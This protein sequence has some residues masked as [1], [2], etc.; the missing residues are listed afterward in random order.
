[1]HSREAK[2][3][4]KVR[5][6]KSFRRECPFKLYV[7]FSRQA[8]CY[9]LTTKNFSHNHDISQEIFKVLYSKNRKLNDS[10]LNEIKHDI[11]MEASNQMIM[12][13]Y[14]QKLQK[15]LIKKDIH[16]IKASLL[17]EKGDIANSITQIGTFY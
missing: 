7:S 16:N 11:E 2:L 1:M 17:K 6:S 5:K 9:F 12:K 10:E 13:K 3:L 14:S 4:S 15:T 8:N